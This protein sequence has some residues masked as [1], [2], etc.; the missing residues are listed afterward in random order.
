MVPEECRRARLLRCKVCGKAGA[1][2]GC[3]I[4]ACSSTYHLPCAML[5]EGAAFDCNAW[6]VYCPVHSDS[7]GS[8]Q[9]APDMATRRRRLRKLHRHLRAAAGEAE[10]LPING[11]VTPVK[12]A[13]GRN[14][15]T[16]PPSA[17]SANP[18]GAASGLPP[19][20][21]VA[22]SADK[23]TAGGTALPKAR[24]KG[25][26]RTPLE[27]EALEPPGKRPRLGA[28]PAAGHS[29]VGLGLSLPPSKPPRSP[30]ARVRCPASPA[31]ANAGGGAEMSAEEFAALAV[32]A[33]ATSL[34]SLEPAPDAL[35]PAAPATAPPSQQQTGLD[36]AP[37]S[38]P[39][40][41]DQSEGVAAA[42][43]ANQR[44]H[45]EQQQELAGQQ[46]EQQG[47][48]Q[49]LAG[50]QQGAQR[51]QQCPGSQLPL[52]VRLFIAEVF[53]AAAPAAIPA[54]EAYLW[55]E[56]VRSFAGKQ[57][58]LQSTGWPWHGS[59][60]CL[61][62]RLTSCPPAPHAWCADIRFCDPQ[63]RGARHCLLC[64]DQACTRC[65]GRAASGRCRLPRAPG[66]AECRLGLAAACLA[67]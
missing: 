51:E 39:A 30:G 43:A 62:S 63:A 27:R 20:D 14:T 3:N 31:K 26:Q 67:L 66:L 4:T 60:P 25:E 45:R 64:G 33:A 38:L 42:A 18:P 19:A 23:M 34:A 56:G 61:A 32:A 65:V 41:R 8:R 11:A 28:P 47:Q 1:A 22:G 46:Q 9:Q 12:A 49:E 37:A 17:T 2:V 44:Q 10:P 15:S 54:A 6:A 59:T 36:S 52:D 13:P 29:P 16:A 50:Q 40:S 57:P 48:E 24:P 53:G 58:C 7:M 55:Q 5:L 21:K 35:P